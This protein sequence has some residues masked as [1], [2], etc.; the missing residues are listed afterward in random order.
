[1]RVNYT[2]YDVRHDQDT[3][4]TGN[5]HDVM[6]LS[7]ES[8]A[9]AHPYWYAHVLGIFGPYQINLMNSNS[10]KPWFISFWFALVG[11]LSLI[12]IEVNLSY[13]KHCVFDVCSVLHV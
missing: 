5:H 1:M 3:I 12:I 11:Y 8:E 2:T 4:S 9:G 6:V 13:F 7:G 10:A